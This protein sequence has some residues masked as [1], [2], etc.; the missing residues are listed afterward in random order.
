MWL[1]LVLLDISASLASTNIE[2]RVMVRV[3]VKTKGLLTTKQLPPLEFPCPI[4]LPSVFQG[5]L[6]CAG[7]YRS[8]SSV[9]EKCEA[10]CRGKRRFVKLF[11]LDRHY[12]L[13]KG[14]SLIAR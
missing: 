11:V 14:M 5:L 13:D 8:G 1:G 10:K 4:T 12:S 9:Q 7:M 6:P 3:R 2:G